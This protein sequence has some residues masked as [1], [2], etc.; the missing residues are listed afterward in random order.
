MYAATVDIYHRGEELAPATKLASK[1]MATVPRVGESIIF[2]EPIGAALVWIVE[3][4]AY[5]VGHPR[6]DAGTYSGVALYVRKPGEEAH[7]YGS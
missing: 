1:R 4:V 6:S 7:T 2:S 5:V 3:H